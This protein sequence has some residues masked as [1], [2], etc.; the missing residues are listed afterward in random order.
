MH[1]KI[2]ELFKTSVFIVLVQKIMK[3]SRMMKKNKKAQIVGLV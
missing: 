3:Q 1:V 2:I